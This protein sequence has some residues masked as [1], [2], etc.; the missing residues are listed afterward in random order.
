VAKK[1]PKKSTKSTVKKAVDAVKTTATTA[2]K[3]AAVAA[4]VAVGSAIPAQFRKPVGET[5]LGAAFGGAAVGGPTLIGA[6]LT[7]GAPDALA[8][9]LFN[10]GYSTVE[11]AL[12]VLTVAKR[13]FA[14]HF[15]LAGSVVDA[16]VKQLAGYAKPIPEE[17]RSVIANTKF[18]FGVALEM[19]HRP[20]R[21][22]DNLSALAAIGPPPAGGGG[23]NLIGFAPNVAIGNAV[24]AAVDLR[25]ELASP[26]HNQG[27]RNT[28]VSHSSLVAYEHYL[29]KVTSGTV[30]DMSEQFLF[31]ACKQRDGNPTNGSGTSMTAA[32]DSLGQ[33][34][35]CQESDWGYDPNNALDQA[36]NPG[37]NPPPQ[38]A[39][40]AAAPFRA[41]QVIRITATSVDDYKRVLASGR[42]AAFAV[43]IYPSFWD[44]PDLF[45]TGKI[46]LPLPNEVT[47][48]GHAMCIV[49]YKDDTSVP[50]LGGGRFILRNSHG[51]EFGATSPY[52][53]GHGTIPYAYIAREGL[54]IGIAFM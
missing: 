20:T 34:G 49:G 2:V 42:C 11:E 53:P 18:S 17:V 28:C 31:W 32:A 21:G 22:S 15:G 12:G 24:P 36:G 7:S 54:D 27:L 46:T 5:P 14:R 1:S 4:N 6:S 39:E 52:G 50:A 13:D 33:A 41:T 35:V 30:Y 43:P 45:A 29:K 19:S 8:T 51:L 44:S 47:K 9:L 3:T 38:G 25:N 37:H 10:L 40:I 26:V 16:L 23:R 48:G